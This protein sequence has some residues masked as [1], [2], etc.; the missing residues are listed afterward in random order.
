[1]F[2]LCQ[3]KSVV[4]LR[5]KARFI[6]R[7]MGR[8]IFCLVFLFSFFFI[9][10]TELHCYSLFTYF[11]IPSDSF[12]DDYPISVFVGN[13][14]KLRKQNNSM[15]MKHEFWQ[16]MSIYCT[17]IQRNST[18]KHIYIKLCSFCTK[19]SFWIFYM[20]V[21]H[22][23]VLLGSVRCSCTTAVDLQEDPL[24]CSASPNLK[25][26]WWTT[27]DRDKPCTSHMLPWGFGPRKAL[28]RQERGRI[29]LETSEDSACATAWGI[30]RKGDAPSIWGCRNDI[31]LCAFVGKFDWVCNTSC[32]HLFLREFYGSY[33]ARLPDQYRK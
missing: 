3:L 8:Y 4:V 18:V 7:I 22:T 33:V 20:A 15:F 30:S 26:C 13:W 24:S 16:L 19:P 21:V 5:Q 11:C 9:L 6:K 29:G 14:H 17:L 27:L 25:P 2:L 32:T 10:M 23:R 12:R 28:L 1:M 31:C